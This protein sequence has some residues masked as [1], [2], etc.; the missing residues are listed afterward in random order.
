MLRWT[1][2]VVVIVILASLFAVP[3]QGISPEAAVK[4]VSEQK[5]QNPI[6]GVWHG[7]ANGYSWQL[8]I[9]RNADPKEHADYVGVML[10]PW[11]FFK[12]GETCLRLTANTDGSYGGEQ[13]WK[14]NAL[15]GTWH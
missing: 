12:R 1:G 13:K 5:S 11:P 3:A 6:I 9:I 8:A 10:Q 2:V 14:T 7:A 15:Y 4:L